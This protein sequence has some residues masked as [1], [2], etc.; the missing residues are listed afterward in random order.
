MIPSISYA[1]RVRQVFKPSARGVVGLVDDL[2]EFC[3]DQPLR[4]DFQDSRCHV[5]PLDAA[6]QEA[7]DVSLQ[8]SVFRAVLARIAALCNE[9]RPN[10]VTPYRGQ[11]ELS[12]G[13]DSP[14]SFRVSFA[15][16]PTELRLELRFI[17]SPPRPAPEAAR[18]VSLSA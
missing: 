18:Q 15:N 1:D 2:L 10:S 4:P 16:T 7:I 14:A 3:R 6:N 8:K 11:G 12:V 9:R 17:A 5:R 13:T